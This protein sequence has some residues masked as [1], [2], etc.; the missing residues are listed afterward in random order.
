MKWTKVWV[1]AWARL[2]SAVEFCDHQ[3]CVSA[4]GQ[5]EYHVFHRRSGWVM[6]ARLDQASAVEFARALEG[7]D[8]DFDEQ[9]E[10]PAATTERLIAVCAGLPAGTRIP[11]VAEVA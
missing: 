9:G 10:C 4:T 8:W 6:K 2:V 1:W 11:D 3:V 7:V 5:G